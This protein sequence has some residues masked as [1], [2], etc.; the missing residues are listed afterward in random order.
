MA[1]QRRVFRIA[2]LGTVGVGAFALL[3][4]ATIQ[5]EQ[6]LQRSRA[7][8]LLRQL[9]AVNLRITTFSNVE[10]V[11]GRRATKSAI[12]D[13]ASC[14]YTIHLESPI[15]WQE[16][17]RVSERL[18]IPD[19][20][21]YQV[22]HRL[23]GR[24]AEVDAKIVVR[25]GVALG[26]SL[27]VVVAGQH[28]RWLIGRVESVPRLPRPRDSES[29]HAALVH[30]PDYVIG[31]PGG[32]TGCAEGYVVFTPHTA[33]ED[34][35]RL[36]ELDLSCLTRWRPCS[37][38]ADIL[39]SAWA[40]YERTGAWEPDPSSVPTPGLPMAWQEIQREWRLR[41][42]ASDRISDPRLIEVLGRD[43]T[44]VAVL[45]ITKIERPNH[46]C[47]YV[48]HEGHFEP[49]GKTCVDLRPT[50][51]VLQVLKGGLWREGQSVTLQASEQ[52]LSFHNN[53]RLIVLLNPFWAADSYDVLRWQVLPPTPK[54]LALV[55]TGI[56]ED[57]KNSGIN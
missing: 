1:W 25:N 33:D 37:T 32:C 31:Q 6:Y 17:F 14:D 23:G 30:Y 29:F 52:E 51:R 28:D 15:G 35:R 22:L 10:R 24:P 9:Q 38:Q 42:P 2:R 26:K 49:T 43:S 21:V 16:L 3:V 57:Y 48:L 19:G 40:Q 8:S 53:E 13:S 46:F 34:V 55:R 5:A 56:A 50:A 18:R 54:N 41:N 47:E 7:E 45:E 20:P 12:C 44:T 11:F 4:L 36:M 27:K 39:P